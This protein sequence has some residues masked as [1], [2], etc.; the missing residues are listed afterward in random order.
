MVFNWFKN[1]SGEKKNII[2]EKDVLNPPQNIS[3]TKEIKVKETQETQETEKS[4]NDIFQEIE[5]PKN[6]LSQEIEGM[7][8]QVKDRETKNNNPEIDVND[9]RDSDIKSDENKNKKEKKSWI[10]RMFGGLE[11]TSS[12]LTDSIS[13]VFTKRKLDSSAIEDLQDIL[14]MS[15]MGVETAKK[16][17]NNIAATRFDK[18]VSDEEIKKA[19]SE[20]IEVVLAP[21]VKPLEVKENHTPHIIMMVGV[22]GSGKTTTIGKL[23][24]KYVADG[25][26][27][28]LGAGDTFRAAAVEQLQVWGQRTGA[29][30]ITKEEGA[31][32]G[33]LAY[34]AIER[35][36]T[37][38]AD[39]LLLDTAGRLHNKEYLMEELK[40][41]NRVVTKLVPNAPHDTI[42]V[43][44][45]TVG[46][47]A[48]EQ[49]KHFSDCVAVSGLIMTKLD[50]SARGGVLVNIANQFDLSIHAIGVG[51]TADDLNAFDA[52]DFAR[53]LTGVKP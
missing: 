22:N 53:G 19:L 46:Q 33:A 18:E 29:I 5:E 14:I 16:F 4:E 52:R 39:V 30:V 36:I 6:D 45:G 13:G 24:S 43:L 23:A 32:A 12:K 50:G 20:E 3:D 11:K 37:E 35:A 7:G 17:T 49:V 47:N 42:L 31:D 1:K 21:R 51:E 9:V 26:K 2:E 8:S 41:I 25:K 34:E 28:M 40:K 15:D 38:K 27:V 48:I 10:G 44:D